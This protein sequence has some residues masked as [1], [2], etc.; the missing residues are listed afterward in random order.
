MTIS[1]YAIDVI[2]ADD[3]GV[4][5]AATGSVFAMQLRRPIHLWKTE[6]A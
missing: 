5:N 4:A 2:P 3:G 1:A 6:W